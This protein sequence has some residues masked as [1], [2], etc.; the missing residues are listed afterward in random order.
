MKE[1]NLILL[2]T[3]I[4]ISFSFSALAHDPKEHMKKPEKANCAE[5]EKMKKDNKKMDKT[6]PVM[7]AMM[8]KC[9]RQAKMMEHEAKVDRKKSDGKMDHKMMDH[10]KMKSNGMK[11]QQKD[12]SDDNNH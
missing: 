5:M 10:G 1:I 9:D 6:D 2:S 7:M 3:T 4:L 8:K 12:K 11:K